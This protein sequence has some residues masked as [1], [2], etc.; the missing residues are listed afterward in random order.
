[1]ALK[2]KSGPS[3]I[4]QGLENFFVLFSF[5]I[6][7][8]NRTITLGGGDGGVGGLSPIYG[9]FTESDNQ[10]PRG[11]ARDLP[12]GNLSHEI[13]KDDTFSFVVNDLTFA[14][15]K[16]HSEFGKKQELEIFT[17]GNTS[18]WIDFGN[19]TPCKIRRGSLLRIFCKINR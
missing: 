19:W 8:V 1:M 6:N 11:Y 14:K 5:Q 15:C 2:L 10:N 9:I 12:G 17:L 16:Q 7:H 3:T 13:V 18:P 4:V